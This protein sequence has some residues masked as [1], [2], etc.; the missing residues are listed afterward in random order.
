MEHGDARN[1][2]IHD[3]FNHYKELRID[4]LHLIGQII[5][6]ADSRLFPSDYRNLMS[7][8]FSITI[9]RSPVVCKLII[10]NTVSPKLIRLLCQTQQLV[11]PYC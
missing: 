5:K 11:S 7:M 9:F 4:L 6:K 1:L 10:K 2:T 8:T 3:S